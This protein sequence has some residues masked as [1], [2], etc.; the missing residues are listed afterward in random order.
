MQAALKRLT[1]VGVAGG[2]LLLLTPLFALATLLIK[3][4]SRGPVLFTQ[5][6]IGRQFRRFRIYK[7]RTMTFQPA[8]DPRLI[9]AAGDPRV[10]RV[11]RLLRWSKIDELP[12]LWNVL[13]GDMSLVGPRPEVPKY[14]ER[15]RRDYEEILTVRPGITDLASLKYRDESTILAQY[16]CPEE[17]YLRWILPDKLRLA[18]EYVRHASLL[19]DLK[20]ILKT[21]LALIR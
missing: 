12:Q 1:E 7:F 15:F 21:L 11:G 13:K 10:T 5:E 4:D 16:A 8:D 3:I 6:R 20:V 17:A 19:L 2:G 9:T 18:K 14:V